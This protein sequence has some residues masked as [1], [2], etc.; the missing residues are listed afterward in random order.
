MW[1]AKVLARFAAEV[2]KTLR[3]MVSIGLACNEFLAKIASDLM[4][5]Y[6]Q[7]GHSV[8]AWHSRPQMPATRSAVCAGSHTRPL[9]LC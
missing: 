2:E 1:P 7:N 3:I 4:S 9:T 8:E 6:D 5:A